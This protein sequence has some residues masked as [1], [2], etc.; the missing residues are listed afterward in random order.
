MVDVASVAD[1]PP[2]DSLLVHVAGTP[3]CLVNVDG[4]VHAIHDVC[5]HALESLTGGYIDGDRIECPRHGAAFSVVTGKALT[6]PANKDL[7]TFRVE[8]RD[9]RVFVDPT[10]SHEHPIA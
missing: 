7:P 3:V 1:V 6:P 10:P 2:G 8:I 9:D 5:T 4:T